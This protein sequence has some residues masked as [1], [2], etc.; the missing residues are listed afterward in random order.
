MGL[1]F[2]VFRLGG[3]AVDIG[4]VLPARAIPS[5][6]LPVFGGLVADRLP[7]GRLL[8]GGDRAAAIRMFTVG[9]LVVTGVGSVRPIPDRGWHPPVDTRR[10]SACNRS[11]AVPAAERRSPVDGCQPARVM[12]LVCRRRGR[13]VGPVHL[14]RTE[15]GGD[16]QFR[17]DR[18]DSGQG[19]RPGGT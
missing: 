10:V 8:I 7:K 11:V 5:I 19:G 13:E 17:C 15:S 3:T 9:A 2:A 6:L 4:S 16:A 1:P 12:A 18:I 14:G